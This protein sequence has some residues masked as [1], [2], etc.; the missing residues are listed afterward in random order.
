M[1]RCETSLCQ[2]SYCKKKKICVMISTFFLIEGASA[3]FCHQF[4]FV[5][6]VIL[7]E[8]Y[9]TLLV[10]YRQSCCSQDVDVEAVYCKTGHTLTQRSVQCIVKYNIQKSTAYYAQYGA[11]QRAIYA[12]CSAVQWMGWRERL[13]DCSVSL[14]EQQMVSRAEHGGDTR[15]Y[16]LFNERPLRSRPILL[17]YFLFLIFYF[18]LS[19]SF[20]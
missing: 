14:I 18:F 16:Q 15:S 13:Y 11:M 9:Y 3:K 7:S 4:H 8:P 20:F 10:L 12:H 17:S 6:L 2:K 5:C 19:S 1:I